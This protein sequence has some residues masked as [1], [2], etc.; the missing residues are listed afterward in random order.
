MD[1]I[2]SGMRMEIFV[3][4]RVMHNFVNQRAVKS[5]HLKPKS[6]TKTCK[7]FK[8]TMM[9]VTGIFCSKPLRFGEW[10][11][12]MDFLVAPLEYHAMILGLE[13]LR[14]SKATPIIHESCLIFLD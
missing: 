10:F 6:C 11:G 9:S 7:F 1:T 12:N 3:D 8:S 14:L 2:V 4:S 13:S 5:L